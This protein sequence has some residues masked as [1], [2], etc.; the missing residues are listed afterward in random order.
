MFLDTSFFNK[1]DID[2]KL[3]FELLCKKHYLLLLKQEYVEVSKGGFDDA[4]S[5]SFSYL[6]EIQKIS[7]E[8]IQL[9]EKF[10]N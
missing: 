4:Q 6:K 2:Q 9:S 10:I 1:T 7:K 8:L 3:A 5:K